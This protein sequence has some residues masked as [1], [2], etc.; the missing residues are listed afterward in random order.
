MMCDSVWPFTQSLVPGTCKK[1]LVARMRWCLR[2]PHTCP[3][4]WGQRCS[5][6]DIYEN[7]IQ[8]DVSF[9]TSTLLVLNQTLWWASELKCGRKKC[10]LVTLHLSPLSIY[11]TI[12]LYLKL[13]S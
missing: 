6:V 11:A 3:C 1:C 10:P 12:S 8:C 9:N 7:I 2:I 13:I 4:F 5:G